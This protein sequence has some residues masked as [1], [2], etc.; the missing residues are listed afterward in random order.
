ML[1]RSLFVLFILA[2]VLYVLLRYT[3]SDYPFGRARVSQ[4]A[5]L[6]DYLTTHT[7]ASSIRRGFAPGFVCYTKGCTRLAAASDKVYQLLAHGRWFS[8]G[9][10]ASS[11]TKTGRDDIAEI[12]LKVALKT[13]SIM[14]TPMVS[15][16]SS[17]TTNVVSS[18]PTQARCTRYNIMWESSSVTCGRSMVLSRYF[19]FLHR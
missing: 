15:S 12:L 14:I 13:K 6:L 4:W 3:Y 11:T 19:D 7:S 2:I 17:I 1:C 8:P 5:R 18:N 9:T 16:I 10:P